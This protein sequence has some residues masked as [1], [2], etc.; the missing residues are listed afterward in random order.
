MSVFSVDRKSQLEKHNQLDAVFLPTVRAQLDP[1]KFGLILHV[2]QKTE[3]HYSRS[4]FSGKASL[5]ASKKSS[6]KT[7]SGKS[8]VVGKEL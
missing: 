3:I 2:V 1:K 6:V 4:K 7:T 8:S 5:G